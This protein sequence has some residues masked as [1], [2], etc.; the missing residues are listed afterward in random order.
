MHKEARRPGRWRLIA[1]D[2]DI[3]LMLLV[4]FSFL[5]VFRYVP[6]GGIF[7]AF[8]DYDIFLGLKNSPFI[9]LANF[10][11]LF[12]TPEFTHV[13]INTLLISLYKLLFFFPLPICL[14]IMLNEVRLM[15][16]KRTIQ[17]IVYMPH[18]LSW[19]I[20]SGLA[21]DMLATNGTFNRIIRALG[22]DTVRF[23]ME[24]RLFRTI[25]VVSAGWK[26]AGFSAIV[27]LASI[28]SIDPAL[29]EAGMVDGANRLQMVWHITLP[30][31][32]PTVVVMLLLRLG[33]VMDAGTEQILAMY[34]PTVYD[35]GDVIG[36]Y[37]YRVGLGSM[38][39][40][41][42]AASGLFNSAISFALV[43]TANGIS[44]RLVQRSLW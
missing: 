13:V 35:T 11:E 37:I 12:A 34:N 43:F 42:A 24:P 14:A 10:R 27:Y 32:L 20:V 9:G 36:T 5:L 21:F 19:V 41:F 22:G 18:F 38:R 15:A 25:L 33:W 17:T 30:G 8:Q 26:E 1:K 44:R 2:Y 3:Y 6:M 7:M 29:Y 31:L 4:P 28:A 40:S 16:F 39:Y 23:L